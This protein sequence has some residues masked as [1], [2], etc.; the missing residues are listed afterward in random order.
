MATVTIFFVTVLSSEFRAAIKLSS[1]RQYELAHAIGVHP[2]TLSG[3]TNGIVPV[4]ADDP[5]LLRLAAILDV[6]ADRAFS[7]REGAAFEVR[8][9]R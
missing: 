3:W 7:Q 8:R 4:R 1:N 5:R 2:S 9:L 6:P